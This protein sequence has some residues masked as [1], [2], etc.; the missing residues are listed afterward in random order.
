MN[1]RADAHGVAQAFMG[2]TIRCTRVHARGSYNPSHAQ[3]TCR[4]DSKW[5][6]API[7]RH[8]ELATFQLASVDTYFR[9][10][11]TEQQRSRSRFEQGAYT[12]VANK[13]GSYT[14]GQHPVRFTMGCKKSAGTP[15]GRFHT[16]R[17]VPQGPGSVQTGV[18]AV[19][20]VTLRCARR[21]GCSA[22]GANPGKRSGRGA[23]DAGCATIATVRSGSAGLGGDR[24]R[25]QG[26]QHYKSSHPRAETETTPSSLQLLAE[27]RVTDRSIRTE[28]TREGSRNG[29]RCAA[30]NALPAAPGG[31]QSGWRGIG[32][33]RPRERCPRRG[34]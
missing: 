31:L 10:L 20:A 26:S 1:T 14:Q 21:A 16:A 24:V 29:P 23:D 15:V 4:V 25:L 11:G 12:T 22:N 17:I 8:D 27:Y 33:A 2:S 3:R 19:G 28:Q 32:W 6:P 7:P 9:Q 34:H 30:S 18:P 13:S 5:C